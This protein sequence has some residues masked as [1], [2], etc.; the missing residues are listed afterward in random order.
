[1]RRTRFDQWPRVK[2]RVVESVTATLPVKDGVL[3][4]AALEAA[5][6]AKAADELGISLKTLY[7][8][9]C[10]YEEDRV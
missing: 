6:D 3:D 10:E 9:L 8:R 1:M 5:T 7:N 2:A 4:V